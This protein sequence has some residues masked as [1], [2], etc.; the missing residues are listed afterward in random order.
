M[1]VPVLR[2]TVISTNL[3]SI[4]VHSM[5]YAITICTIMPLYKSSVDRLA[6]RRCLYGS[7]H[8]GSA[9]KDGPKINLCYSAFPTRLVNSGIS[10]TFCCN[11]PR[12]FRA[13]SF[14]RVRWRSFLT[15]SLQDSPLIRFILIGCHQIH[16]VVSRP[17]LK[18][19]H[20]FL[21]IFCSAF[22]WYNTDY[23]TVLRV[24]GH[25]VPIV[26]LTT[27]IWLIVTAM[28]FFLSDKRPFLVKLHFRG[29]W[30]KTLPTDR[31]G[32]GHGSSGSGSNGFSF[33]R[34]LLKQ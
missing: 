22:S 7:F 33:I 29:L 12:T 1:N 9:A 14:A 8:I 19:G 25:M 6:N 15:V 3:L 21:N 30:G 17:F 20:Q 16:K 31:E 24:I 32:P 34:Q 13:A 28:F 18:I 4:A 23:Q 5:A 27:I 2:K 11:T 26:S 10:Q